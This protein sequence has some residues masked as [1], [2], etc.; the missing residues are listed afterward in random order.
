MGSKTAQKQNKSE[1]IRTLAAKGL[2]RAEIAKKMG[3]R[4]QFVR[5]VLVQHEDKKKRA[6]E[7]QPANS[8]RVFRT[9]LG[10]DGRIVIAA[11]IR[12][13]LGLRENQTLLLSIEE[14]ELRIRTME[15]AI[16]R[17]QAFV[18]RFVPEGVSLADELLEDRRREVEQERRGG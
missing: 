18:R 11:S 4:Y 10:A 5:N 15:A 7:S 3:V 8:S 2:S 16:R 6:K 1:V 13:E 14:G 17:V 9:N 12:E